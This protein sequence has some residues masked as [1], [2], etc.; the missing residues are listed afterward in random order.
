MSIK[1][2]DDIRGVRNGAAIIRRLH[3]LDDRLHWH[4]FFRRSDLVERFSI[5]PQQAS[6]DIGQ[7]QELA[8][9]NARFDSATKAYFRA[10]GFAPLFPKNAFEWLKGAEVDGDANVIPSESIPC[11]SH[12]TDDRVMAA[13]I[14]AY[15]TRTALTIEYQSLTS[16]EPSERI[17]CPHHVVDTRHRVH[18]RAWDDRRRIFTDFVLSRVLSARPEPSYPWVDA[19]ADSAWNEGVEVRLAPHPDLSPFQRAVI[20]REYGMRDG[21]VVIPVRKALVTYLLD[22][23]GLLDPVRDA[24]GIPDASRGTCCLNPDELRPHL[25]KPMVASQSA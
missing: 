24:D 22:D 9:V 16:A 25:P 1:S 17:I 11:P 7:Y 8:P 15:E 2:V 14:A 10:D 23:L 3:W 4:G 19:I 6:T 12:R 18:I 21:A 5:S 13:V 20:E